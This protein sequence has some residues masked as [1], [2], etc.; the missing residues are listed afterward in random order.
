MIQ[1]II[2]GQL[3]W[4]SGPIVVSSDGARAKSIQVQHASLSRDRE[5]RWYEGD[6]TSSGKKSIFCTYRSW[7][8]E[9]FDNNYGRIYSD[10]N[11]FVWT[12]ERV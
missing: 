5:S 6:E 2:A 8:C 7:T 3:D 9:S 1:G 11:S 4:Q 10:K 12:I